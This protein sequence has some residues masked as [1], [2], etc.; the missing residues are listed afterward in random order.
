MSER[1]PSEFTRRSKAFSVYFTPLF[2]HTPGAV[3]TNRPFFQRVTLTLE[4]LDCK[5]SSYIPRG[6]S[7]PFIVTGVS[8]NSRRARFFLAVAGEIA[9]NKS[10]MVIETALIFI[11]SPYSSLLRRPME[12]AIGQPRSLLRFC[13][14]A[15][16]RPDSNWLRTKL[17]RDPNWMEANLAARATNSPLSRSGRGTIKISRSYMRALSGFCGE[18]RFFHGMAENGGNTFRALYFQSWRF[19]S[20]VGF[21]EARC[22]E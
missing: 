9:A 12:I 18:I 20:K 14:L 17:A 15:Q 11:S 16:P 3:A 22:R 5:V 21:R 10:R 19:D 1:D 6:I 4:L 13:L 7:A 2:A 8:R